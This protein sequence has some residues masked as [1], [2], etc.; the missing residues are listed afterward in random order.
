MKTNSHV[1]WT[2]LTWRFKIN[3]K[4]IMIQFCE[5]FF[6]LDNEM[7]VYILICVTFDVEIT[8]DVRKLFEPLKSYKNYFDFKN[9]EIL[10][11]HENENYII[12]LIFDA[13]SLYKLLY[14]LFETELDIL[15]NYLLKNLILNRIREFTNRANAS[16]FFV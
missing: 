8:F 12:I 4:K 16:M 6:D 14:T 3:F 10:F 2:T 13:K 11:K 15:K 5:N 1:D 9:A 7:S